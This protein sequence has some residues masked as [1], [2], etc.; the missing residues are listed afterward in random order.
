MG[1]ILYLHGFQSKGNNRKSQ[2]LKD[3]FGDEVLSPNLPVDPES[4]ERIILSAIKN[5]KDLI[6]VGT[7]LGGFWA[8]YFSQITSSPCV[9]VNPLVY[10][11]YGLLRYKDR[12]MR[13]RMGNPFTITDKMLSIYKEKESYLDTHHNGNLVTLFLAKDDRVIPHHFALDLIDHPCYTTVTM[14]G[15]HRYS[16]HWSTVMNRIEIIRSNNGIPTI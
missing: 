7:S 6:F 3:R 15:G 4:A 13:D 11:S 16:S 2:A 8:R 12:P 14:D 9:L 1:K 5:H 10:P